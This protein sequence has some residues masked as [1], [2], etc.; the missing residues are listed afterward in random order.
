MQGRV[1]FF[2]CPTAIQ[3]AVVLYAHDEIDRSKIDGP[4]N[5]TFERPAGSHPLAAAAQRGRWADERGV[6][7]T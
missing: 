2:P 6:I 4:D 3:I 1:A 5:F 7:R